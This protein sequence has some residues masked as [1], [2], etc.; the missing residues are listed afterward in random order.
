MA[1]HQAPPSLGLSRQEHWSE[2]PF[3]SPYD[4]N[5]I[6][7]IK[8]KHR[9]YKEKKLQTNIDF[10]TEISP[11]ILGTKFNNVLKASHT[12]QMEFVFRS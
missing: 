2:L 10:D 3:P 5:T 4:A 1:A 6:S 7:N 11:K 9:H 12:A 8:A